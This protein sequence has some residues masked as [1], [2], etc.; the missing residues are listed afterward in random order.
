MTIDILICTI[1]NGI[2]CVS[3]VLMP[4]MPDVRYVVSMQ[5]TRPLTDVAEWSTALTL[6]RERDDVTVLTLE[7]R[8]LSRNRNNALHHATADLLVI[9]DDDCRYT[10]RSI[11]RIR[12]AYAAH[13]EADIICFEAESYDGRPMKRYPA[14]AM[15]YRTAQHHGYYPTSMEL[16]LRRTALAKGGA[17]LN[18]HFGLGAELPA[19]EEEVWLCDMMRG[20]CRV[21]FVP[22]VI[23]RSDPVTTGDN[24]LTDARLQ[25]TKGAVFRHCYGVADSLWRTAKEGAYHLVYHH[26]NPW[27]IWL[28]ML[29]GVW[30]SR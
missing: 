9:A 24:F 22:E 7:G 18:E 4:P 29:R 20:G 1:D 26:I 19:G 25:V 15:D 14:A 3:Q 8:G 28:N 16:T 30:I 27:P 2:S 11:E 5:H 21:E 12:E 13:P 23:T 10:P 6:L 17:A